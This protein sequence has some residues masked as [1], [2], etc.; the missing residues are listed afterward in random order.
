MDV[1]RTNIQNLG[2]Q[3]DVRRPR[4]A[5]ARTL[6]IHLPLTLAIIPSL[7][8]SVAGERFAIPQVNVVEVVRLKREARAGRAHPLERG[9]APARR[10]PA[11]G[12]PRPAASASRRPRAQKRTRA[13]VVVLRSGSHLY[14]LVVD[15]LHDSEEI[16]V[17]P[18]ST[19][20]ADCGWYAGATILGDGRVAMILDTIGIAKRAQIRFDEVADEQRAPRARRAGGAARRAAPLAGGLRERRRRALRGAA[21]RAAAARAR[22]E[23]AG[24]VGR[25]RSRS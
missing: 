3:I 8:V 19:H 18:V 6:R 12:A 20:L 25:R 2:G 14:G 22:R 10:A 24:R 4:S 17:K 1:V 5:K 15:E 23:A 9:A 13:N 11:A 7:I 16:V 21:A